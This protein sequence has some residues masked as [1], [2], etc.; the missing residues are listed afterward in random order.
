MA[1]TTTPQ[2][3]TT[4]KEPEAAAAFHTGRSNI[5]ALFARNMRTSGI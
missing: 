1:T 4:P 5:R 3:D 2:A